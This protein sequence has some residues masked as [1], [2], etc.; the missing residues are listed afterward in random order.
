MQ[1]SA[2]ARSWLS[3]TFGK[4]SGAGFAISLFALFV[5]HSSSYDLY[6][7]SERLSAPFLWFVFYVY[8]MACSLLIDWIGL[9]FPRMHAI[10]KTALYLSAGFTFFMIQGINA[11][12]VIAGI[13]GALCALT[14]YAGTILSVQHR[15]F[16][17]GF[18]IVIPLTLLFVSSID[19]TEK[20][21]WKETRT[22]STYEA[23]FDYFNGKHEIPISVEK[24]ETI[25]FSITVKNGNG[26]GHGF[27]VTH[28]NDRS[29]AMKEVWTDKLSIFSEEG[30]T[31][32]IVVT[33]NGLQ[34]SIQVEWDV[35]TSHY[36]PALLQG[37]LP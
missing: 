14:F 1:H 28:D 3:F 7:F 13:V 33:G 22:D 25:T 5:L 24:G 2:R 35:S 27:Y 10:V 20:R 34:G 37:S 12:A 29:V 6:V 18:A 16:K 30:G 26:G 36:T 17:Y 32:R 15:I 19:F 9:R 4:L 31:Y 23:S 11:F 8:G 21:E